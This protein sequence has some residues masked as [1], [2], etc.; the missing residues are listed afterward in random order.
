MTDLHNNN[1]EENTIVCRC[2]DLD[3]SKIRKLIKD[4]YTTIEDLKRVA[5]LGMGIC[6]GRTCIPLALQE[7]SKATGIP[8]SELDTGTYRPMVKSIPMGVIA[9]SLTSKEK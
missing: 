3:V 8:V 6:Q 5:R 1:N 2:S 9:D 4:G 7:L